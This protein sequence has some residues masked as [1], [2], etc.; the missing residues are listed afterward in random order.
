M[1]TLGKA[2]LARMNDVAITKVEISDQRD[3][4]TYRKDF[5]IGDIIAVQG[6]YNATAN[7]RVTEYVEMEDESGAKSYP[8]LS[9]L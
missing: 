7:M 3:S 5:N 6:N 8:T 4:W 1:Y 9:F 2:A